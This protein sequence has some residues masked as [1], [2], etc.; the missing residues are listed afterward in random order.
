[1]T[2]VYLLES[3]KDPDHY[4]VGRTTNLEERLKQHNSADQGHTVK[5]R[6]WKLVVA[7]QFD[8]A[9][10]AEAFEL[11]LKSGSGRAFS[12]KHF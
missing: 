7:I 4:Y 8:D 5:F 6:P 11:Y 10:K 1:M 12:K 3:Q 9:A 2:T